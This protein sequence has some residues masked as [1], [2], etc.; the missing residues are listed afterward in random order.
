MQVILIIGITGACRREELHQLT[1]DNVKDEKT[2][3]TVTLPNTKTH[4]TRKFTINTPFKDIVMQ[5]LALRPVSVRHNNFFLNYQKGKCTSQVIGINKIGKCPTVIA[6]WLGLP[7]P[8]LY[9]GHALR[10]TSATLLADAGASLTV[11]KRHGGWKSS[12]VA[13]G[14]IEDSIANKRKICDQITDAIV[15]ETSCDSTVSNVLK[16]LKQ[17]NDE[18]STS[19][20]STA[21]NPRVNI[22]LDNC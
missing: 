21:S 12:Q 6:Q 11:L 15:N 8:E 5:Y 7:E 10:R 17:N 3:F 1:V 9:T 20:E 2:H 14:Y 16:K 4:I 22:Q 19:T 13:E 18:N